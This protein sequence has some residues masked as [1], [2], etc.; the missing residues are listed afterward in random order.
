MVLA[1]VE[2]PG[3]ELSG[4]AVAFAR[5]LDAGEVQT[6]AIDG[7]A[8]YAPAAWAAGLVS[9]IDS[10]APAAVIGPG[11]DR[12]NEVLAHVAAR[13]DLPLSANTVSLTLGDPASVVRVRWGGSLL[14]EARLHA[15]P[16][17]ATVAPHAVAAEPLSD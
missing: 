15:A 1:F 11:S 14:E 3:D 6:V 8:P 12:G 13:L 10:R 7:G 9:A 4:Q 2:D 5:G 17:L 16:V